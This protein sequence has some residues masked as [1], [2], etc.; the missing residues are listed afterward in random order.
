[1]LGSSSRRNVTAIC[2]DARQ[3]SENLKATLGANSRKRAVNYTNITSICEHLLV[4]K[5]VV[6][7]TADTVS[8]MGCRHYPYFPARQTLNNDYSSLL[9]IWRNAYVEIL[10]LKPRRASASQLQVTNQADF[11]REIGVLK[12]DIK[13]LT[14][15]LARAR[16]VIASQSILPKAE[17]KCSP[18][19]A[20][21][22]LKILR[23]WL[24]DIREQRGALTPLELAPAGLKVSSRA[25]PGMVVMK[26]EVVDLL[27]RFE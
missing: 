17:E 16:A 8:T 3:A 24:R 4:A 19:E 12:A 10:R 27:K 14:A 1:M 20:L 22:T 23:D 15:D 21:A 26:P 5:P 2:E 9:N 25:R 18:S 13:L 11:D 7:P 6:E